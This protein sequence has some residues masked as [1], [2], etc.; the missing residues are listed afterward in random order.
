[1]SRPC[2]ATCMVS[3]VFIVSMIYFQNRTTSSKIV[4]EYKAQLPV[5]LQT[6]YDQITKERLRIYYYGYCLGFILSAIIIAFTN[7]K[8]VNK[9]CLVIV[10]SF[11]TNYFY[12]ILSPKSN[13]MLDHIH[14]P[15]QTKAWLAMYRNMQVNYHV[16][17]VLGILGLGIFAFAFH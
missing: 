16:G 8:T 12:Y 3:F 5:H 14:S 17:F 11:I 4:Q 1:M 9:V 15:T 6:I 2:S 7:T 13:W 10:V